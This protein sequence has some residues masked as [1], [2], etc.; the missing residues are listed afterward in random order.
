MSIFDLTAQQQLAR[1][2]DSHAQ[3]GNSM[4]LDEVQGFVAAL[5]SGPDAADVDAW[6]PEILADNVAF[7]S[8]EQ[9]DIRRLVAQMAEQLQQEMGLNSAP[10]LLLYADETGEPDY[11][12][13]CNAYLYALDV[14]PTDWFAQQD[15]EGFEDL[16]YPIMALGGVYDATDDQP[17]LLTI[18]AAE[19]GRLQDE[20]PEALLAIYRYWQVRKHTPKTL[21]RQGSKIG[22]NEPCPC[23]SGKKY[24][25][26]CGQ[27]V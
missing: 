7:G 5:A 23:G 6:L 16:F 8:E 22:R 14:T 11:Y 9:A 10:E 20:L 3:Q 2:L 21:R 25:A 17:A 27:K 18:D 19:R 24:K 1:L 13:W 15:D 12:T 4:R 26:C